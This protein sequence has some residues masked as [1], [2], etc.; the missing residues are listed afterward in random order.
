MRREREAQIRRLFE[1]WQREDP[2]DRKVKAVGDLLQEID[3]YE[4]WG[5]ATMEGCVGILKRAEAAIEATLNAVGSGRGA[6]GLLEDISE[7]IRQMDVS[8]P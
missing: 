6:S 5:Q 2:T 4:A 7:A 1:V 3:R 8:K